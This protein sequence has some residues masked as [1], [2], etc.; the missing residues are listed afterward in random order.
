MFVYT[1]NWH[2]AYGKWQDSSQIY[3]YITKYK[4]HIWL[5][6]IIQYIY[7]WYSSEKLPLSTFLVS[8]MKWSHCLPLCDV[9]FSHI[10][11]SRNHILWRQI[12]KGCDVKYFDD[13]AMSAWVWSFFSSRQLFDRQNL[14]RLQFWSISMQV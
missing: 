5:I 8:I 1:L 13:D 6:H 10:V 11:T 2:N 9:R 7:L 4:Q 12:I 3:Y 14:H